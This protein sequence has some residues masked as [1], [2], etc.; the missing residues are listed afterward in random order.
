MTKL[1]S[2]STVNKYLE[3]LEEADWEIFDNYAGKK[4]KRGD[5]VLIGLHT[6]NKYDFN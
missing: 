4:T 6:S 2:N 3:V 5:Y 1:N